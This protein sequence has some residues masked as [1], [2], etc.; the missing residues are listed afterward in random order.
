VA[1]LA[2]ATALQN[3]DRE[4]AWRWME[5][6]AHN[7]QA[8][9]MWFMGQG[10]E[11]SRGGQPADPAQ[12]LRWYQ[13][14]AQA[15]LVSAWRSQAN[16]LLSGK[17]GAQDFDQAM[18]L[19]QQG[20]QGGD[21]AAQVQIAQAYEAGKTLVRS[22]PMAYAWANVAVSELA[23][24]RN[25]AT[26]ALSAQAG[27][28]RDRLANQ[29]DTSQLQRAQESGR[30]W[31]TGALALQLQSAQDPLERAF[32]QAQPPLGQSLPALPPA[33]L[34]GTPPSATGLPPTSTLPGA[35]LARRGSGSAFYVSPQ[36][37]LV[38]N[39]HV[40][41]GCVQMRLAGNA[42]PLLV[43]GSDA[44]I[45]LALLQSPDPK[46]PKAAGI[47]L[48]PARQGEEIITYG[49]PLQGL[50]ASGGQIATGIVS[51]MAGLRNDAN[52]LQIN[53]AVQPGSS[54]G[55]LLDKR[56]EV[57]GVVVSKLNALRIAQST[58]DIPQN[59][60]FAIKPEVLVRFLQAQGITPLS[61]PGPL[62]LN[63]EQLAGIAREYTVAIECWR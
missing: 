12:A 45:D 7:G 49:Y 26:Q 10:L 59:V 3:T 17:A 24:L 8:V 50:L 15:G 63:T 19:L 35:A 52:L 42:Q 38:T 43:Q 30:Q 32:R 34:P 25:P 1:Q 51:A 36:G 22:I 14:A 53:A 29:L 31:R 39:F 57:V 23:A 58:G 55:P 46:A 9:A 20:A 60:N 13:R 33:E 21:P 28:L 5:K 4:N 44:A 47:R 54:G 62:T 18:R 6:A 37:H 56:G 27:T 2:L 48:G 16:L 40:V 61:N 41:Q 11:N